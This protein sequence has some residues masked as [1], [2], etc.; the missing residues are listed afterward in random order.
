MKDRT[1]H[2]ITTQTTYIIVE[3]DITQSSGKN[4]SDLF[5]ECFGQIIESKNA[6]LRYKVVVVV[7]LVV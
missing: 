7:E 4:R 6:I 5:K 2:Y 3:L 1:V